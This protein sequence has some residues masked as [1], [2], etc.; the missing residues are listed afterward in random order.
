[1]LHR[2]GLEMQCV[3]CNT[4]ESKCFPKT[5][6]L[7]Y[8][9]LLPYKGMLLGEM[10][11]TRHAVTQTQRSASVTCGYC[12]LHSR[13]PVLVLVK[14]FAL[15][16]FGSVISPKG[17]YTKGLVTRLLY[18]WKVAEPLGPSERKLSHWGHALEGDCG[19]PVSQC[20]CF[21]A[22]EVTGLLCHTFLP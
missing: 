2:A 1:M 19:I 10:P 4:G 5:L 8:K 7:A 14:V 12:S 9:D 21:L 16:Q 18:Y 6:E 13:K 3:L 15:L 20:L 22:H 17:S 11:S